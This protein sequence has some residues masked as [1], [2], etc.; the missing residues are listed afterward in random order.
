MILRTLGA[1]RAR[2]PRQ[3]VNRSGVDASPIIKGTQVPTSTALYFV[4]MEKEHPCLLRRRNGPCQQGR[5]AL[6]PR[7]R[8]PKY[9]ERSLAQ[10][11]TAKTAYAV[12]STRQR[13]TTLEKKGQNGGVGTG[14]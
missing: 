10:C 6:A 2:A 14:Y 9:L 13:A 11:N 12:G 8:K 4:G 3:F 1:S 7:A 5:Q